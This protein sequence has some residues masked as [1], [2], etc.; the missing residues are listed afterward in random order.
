MSL[1]PAGK[2]SLAP[3]QGARLLFPARAVRWLAGLFLQSV[4]NMISVLISTAHRQRHIPRLPPTSP[5][6][7]HTSPRNPNFYSRCAPGKRSLA[8]FRGARLL[9]PDAQCGGFLLWLMPGGQQGFTYAFYRPRDDCHTRAGGSAGVATEP[10]SSDAA[11]GD[12]DLRLEGERG[13]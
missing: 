5:I 11:T 1:C 2:R 9:F 6:R 8:P 4:E 3:W 10:V 7:N 13:G 12:A